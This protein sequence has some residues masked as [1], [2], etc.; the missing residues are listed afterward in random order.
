MEGWNARSIAGY[1]G[2]GRPAVYRTLK[3]W[4]AEDVRGLEDE[5]RGGR[6]KAD[7]RTMNEVPKLQENPEPTTK[8]LAGFDSR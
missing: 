8:K 1:L 2:T 3:R 4:I 5:P 7:L 6:R